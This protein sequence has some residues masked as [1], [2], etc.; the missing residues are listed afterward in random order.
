MVAL[1]V[2][3][4]L[5]GV[6]FVLVTIPAVSDQAVG[7]DYRTVIGAARSYLD[8]DGFYPAA[9]LAGPYPRNAGPILY[10]PVSLWLFAPFVA[11]PAFLWWAIPVALTVWAFV[12]LRPSAAALA[13]VGLLLILPASQS[14]IIYG[15]PVMW[16]V[17]ALAWGLMR[18]GWAVAILAKPSLAP[19]ALAGV[20]RRGWWVGLALFVAASL[21]FGTMWF[22]WIVAVEHGG[23]PLT[24]SLRQVPLMLIPLVAWLGRSRVGERDAR[25][26]QHS[27]KPDASG[28]S[29]RRWHPDDPAVAT[30]ALAG[31]A[32]RDRS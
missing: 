25:P 15:N 19:F 20:R 17:P 28:A 7:I 13:V 4:G 10:P 31:D 26:V 6:H 16:L 18:G 32:P 21:P 22:D 9:Q 5:R 29:A 3:A 11:L 30:M 12:R 8:G 27:G 2:A 24:H 1:F 14:P 23:V